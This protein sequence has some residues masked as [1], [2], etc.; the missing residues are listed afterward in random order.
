LQKSINNDKLF[1]L[2]LLM[3][4]SDKDD[5]VRTYIIRRTNAENYKSFRNFV[6]SKGGI[7]WTYKYI[8]KELSF[9]KL[10]KS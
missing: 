10:S 3:V 7:A 6:K 4:L 5:P 8:N 1:C 2:W 9:T